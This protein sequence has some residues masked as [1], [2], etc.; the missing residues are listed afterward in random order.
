MAKA[1][2]D[3]CNLDP[4]VGR[5]MAYLPRFYYDRKEGKCKEFIY[6]GCEGNKNNF[7]KMGDCQKTCGGKDGLR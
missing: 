1:R 4:E 3:F 7:G 6:G 2:P 5:C